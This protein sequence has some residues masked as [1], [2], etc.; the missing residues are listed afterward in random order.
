MAS[1]MR[2]ADIAARLHL[3]PK[4]VANRIS[5]IFSKLQVAHRGEAIEL[6]H[7]TRRGRAAESPRELMQ[8]GQAELEEQIPR[9]REGR[10]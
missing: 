2:N 5:L 9:A 6:V 1:G 3:S 8:P 7:R 10:P 4:T